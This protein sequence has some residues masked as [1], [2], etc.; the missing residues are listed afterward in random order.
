MTDRSHLIQKSLQK[1]QT[2]TQ[3]SH[4]QALVYTH[5]HTHRDKYKHK[6]TDIRARKGRNSNAVFA[7]YDGRT[8][9]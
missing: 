5:E 3:Q 1:A 2:C 7:T 6:Y 4:T 9:L 8:A